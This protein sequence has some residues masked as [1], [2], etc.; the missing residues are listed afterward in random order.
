MSHT[1]MKMNSG[2][3]KFQKRVMNPRVFKAYMLGKA[4]LLGVTGA[5]LEHLDTHSGR[6]ILP[7]SRRVKNLFGSVFSAAL[8]AGAETLTGALIV[9]HMRNQGKKLSARVASCSVET[10]DWEFSDLKLV[11][12]DGERYA[13]FVRRVAASGIQES[14]T[15]EVVASS[16]STLTHRISLTWTL[17]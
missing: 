3:Q 15:F 6:L 1:D 4:P 13:D 16:G 17:E 7:A 5:Y 10:L 8:L 14:E 9:L 12:H 11:A 2:G